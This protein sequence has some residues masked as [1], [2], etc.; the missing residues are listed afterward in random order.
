MVHETPSAPSPWSPC[1]L[2]GRTQKLGDNTLD[3]STPQDSERVAPVRRDDLVVLLN[4]RV[5]PNRHGLLFNPAKKNVAVSPSASAT[6]PAP[7][8]FSGTAPSAPRTPPKKRGR[9]TWPMARWQKPRMSFCRRSMRISRG[10]TE[11]LDT[12]PSANSLLPCRAARHGKEG[13]QWGF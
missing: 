12:A 7:G 2:A 5:H 4:R 13:Y 11:R 6:S 9:L 3:R 8:H 1:R 10:R